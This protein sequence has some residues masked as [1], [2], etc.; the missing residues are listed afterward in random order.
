[1]SWLSQLMSQIEGV[2]GRLSEI[3]DKQFIDEINKTK[4]LA[5]ISKD[6]YIRKIG[7]VCNT[8]F[9]S[10]VSTWWIIHHPEEMRDACHRYGKT[11]KVAQETLAQYMVPFMYLL[12][13]HREIQENN[14][15]IK[16]KWV[17]I[18]DEIREPPA[19]LPVREN[20]PTE[21]QSKA[22]MS[23]KEICKIRDKLD[24][25]SEGRLLLS[26]YTILKPVRSDFDNV[27]IYFTKPKEKDDGNYIVLDDVN[28]LYLGEY[29]T[30]E[31]YGTSVLDLPE[32]LVKQ[33]KL[34]LKRNPREYLFVSKFGQ[35]FNNASHF[36]R[37][38]NSVIRNILNNDYI[39]LTTFRHIYL[40]QTDLDIENMPYGERKKIA[41]E[42]GHSVATQKKYL[43]KEDK[44]KKPKK[45]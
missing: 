37:W 45:S 23:F 22:N 24:D 6:T 5:Q 15:K 26:F 20:Q 10:K 25:G 17:E 30:S 34:S 43:W 32:E 7:K 35:P 8:F 40:S 42:M 38:A 2:G 12:D 21:K 3:S 18:R 16:R 4:L 13:A 9:P 39:T 36:G 11:K 19:D 41:H 1:M 31:K 33:I 27:R 44:A 28:K 29:K 14:P